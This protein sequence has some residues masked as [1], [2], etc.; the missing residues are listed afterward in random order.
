VDKRGEAVDF[1]IA[2]GDS[3]Q[4]SARTARKEEDKQKKQGQPEKQQESLLSCPEMIG[5]VDPEE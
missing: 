5:L 3:G 2:A 4:D 1:R